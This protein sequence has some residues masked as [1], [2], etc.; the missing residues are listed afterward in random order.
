MRAAAFQVLATVASFQVWWVC[1]L[2]SFSR[3]LVL[4]GKWHFW[5]VG[6]LGF[7]GQIEA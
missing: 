2:A 4:V 5:E 6:R 1:V 7:L 3:S